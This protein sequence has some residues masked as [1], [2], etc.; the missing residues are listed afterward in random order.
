M[1]VATWL[2]AALLREATFRNMIAVWNAASLFRRIS[3]IP[4]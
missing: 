2:I 3:A 1:L 4:L